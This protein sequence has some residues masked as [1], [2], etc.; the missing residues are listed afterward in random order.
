MLVP[1]L[2]ALLRLRMSRRRID[3]VLLL[4]DRRTK[5][6][7]TRPQHVIASNITA[8]GDVSHMDRADRI[9]LHVEL[10][11]DR[12]SHLRLGSLF[13]LVHPNHGLRA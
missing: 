12:R 6:L 10:A 2:R 9:G 7:S 3:L 8:L 13:R 1:R 4:Q 11:F 5:F